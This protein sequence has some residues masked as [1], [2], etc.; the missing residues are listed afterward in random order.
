M[1]DSRTTTRCSSTRVDTSVE[2]TAFAVQ[3]LARRDPRNPLLERA[4]RWLMLNRTGGYWSIDQADGDGAL[5]PAGVLQARNESRAAVHRR[6]LRQRHARPARRTF[7]AASLTAPDPI[8]DLRSRRNAGANRVRIVKRGRRR[9]STGRRRRATTTPLGGARA[10]ARRQLAH[11]AQLRPA[12]PPVTSQGGRIV[13]RETPFAGTAKPGDVLTV[14]LTVAGSTD[15]RYLVLEDPLPAGVEAV[16]DTTAYPLERETTESHWWSGSRVEYR[17]SRTVFFQ[18]TFESGRYEYV[19]LV[20][21]ISSG[22]FRAIPAQVSP[23]YVPGVHG[24]ERAAD[25]RDHRSC[26]RVTMKLAITSLWLLV[27]AALTGAVYWTFL[28]TP[29]STVGSLALSALLFVVA[30]FLLA[31]TLSGAMLAWSPGV[32]SF[33]LRAAVTSA[34]A[35]VPAAFVF[36]AIWWLVG[37]VTD[38]V[39]IYSGQINAWFIA[40]FGWDDVSLLFRGINWI[41]VWLKWVVASMLAFSLMSAVI[42]SGWR[43]LAGVAWIKH[44]LSP[45]PAWSRDPLLRRPDRRAVA[46]SRTLAAGRLARHLARNGVHRRQAVAH[47]GADQRSARRL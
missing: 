8:V 32:S 7:A 6:R 33:M 18:E 13:Y 25:V 39:T 47:G 36:A 20:K 2:A 9:R 21:V 10:A 17:D 45:A 19:Y 42:T 31:V 14:R 41:A 12:V 34:P 24:L 44:A 26:G 38:Q 3:A 27:G 23:M 28:I 1:V 5:R 43:A 40:T 11:H 22:Q 15:W 46:L 16:Q 29:E 37:S 35:I 30:C 4:V